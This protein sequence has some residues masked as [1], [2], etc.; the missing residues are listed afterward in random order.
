MNIVFNKNGG[1]IAAILM[2]MCVCVVK[3]RYILEY[4]LLV[5]S[6]AERSFPSVRICLRSVEAKA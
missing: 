6:G 1:E 3:M 2:C 5:K 4:G